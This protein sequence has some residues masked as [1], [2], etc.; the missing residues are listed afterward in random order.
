MTDKD[1]IKQIYNM[2][3]DCKI[4]TSTGAEQKLERFYVFE[5]WLKMLG[6]GAGD[7]IEKGRFVTL[8]KHRDEIEGDDRY[9]TEWREECLDF[10]KEQP[11]GVKFM[12][13]TD[14]KDSTFVKYNYAMGKERVQ[15]EFRHYE[16][17]EI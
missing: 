4:I 1:K 15:A 8:L 7:A 17:D 12:F 9:Y 10:V 5:G 14:D 11:N 6:L 2:Q 3:L 16:N 13:V